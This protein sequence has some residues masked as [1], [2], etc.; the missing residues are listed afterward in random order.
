MGGW[1]TGVLSVGE[2]DDPLG[3]R[4]LRSFALGHTWTGK[5]IGSARLQSTRV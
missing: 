4:D 1:G 3:V 2:R 5:I